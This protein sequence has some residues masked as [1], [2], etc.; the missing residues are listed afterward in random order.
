M[1]F[2]ERWRKWIHACISMVQYLVLINGSLTDFCNYSRDLRQEDHLSP[3]LFLLM[4]EFLSRIVGRI[5]GVSFIKC[6]RTGV[7]GG[8][9][10][11]VSPLLFANDTIFC[12]ANLD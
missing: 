12:D 7:E 4:M 10:L 2:G 9:G 6:F 11:C 3:V 5:E 1:D 8:D